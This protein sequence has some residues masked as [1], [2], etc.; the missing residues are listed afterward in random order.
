[1]PL[2]ALKQQPGGGPISVFA[3]KYGPRHHLLV[4][5]QPVQNQLPGP[6]FR[7]AATGWQAWAARRWVGL[8]LTA[9]GLSLVGYLA[10]ASAQPSRQTPTDAAFV[11]I[12][13]ALANILAAFAF[14]SVGTV[15]ATHARSAVARLLRIARTLTTRYTKMTE[16][17]Q[18][19]SEREVAIE[20]RVMNAEVLTA[21]LTL[22][23]A[24]NDWNEVHGEALTEVLR[25]AQQ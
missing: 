10:Y 3:A 22:R 19:G 23:D 11:A 21:I 16:V 25:D 5:I 12:L 17:L 20:A 8:A 6:P 4:Y 15:T 13:A 9:I 2:V 14:A 7:L 24:I 1:M 18:I